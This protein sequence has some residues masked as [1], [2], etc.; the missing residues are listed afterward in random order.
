MRQVRFV[1]GFVD[2]LNDALGTIIG[3]LVLPMTLILVWEVTLRY[4]FNSPTRWAHETSEF[5]YAAHFLL[6]GAYCLRR[7]SHVNVGI[8][9]NRFP[10]RVRAI[11]DLVTW[12]FFYL[13]LGVLLWK[14]LVAGWA[15]VAVME[16][17]QSAWGPPYWPIK[18]TIPLAAVLMLLQGLRK[19]IGNIFLAITG[20]EFIAEVAGGE[21][22]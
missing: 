4:G 7:G 3:V 20:R 6:A 12:L 19:T 15:S 9:Y 21:G 13:F 5:L 22:L 10:S 1:I 11:V 17:T 2:N 8:L 16:V 14:G 18:L